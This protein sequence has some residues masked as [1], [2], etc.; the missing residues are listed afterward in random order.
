MGRQVSVERAVVP[1]ESAGLMGLLGPFISKC[2]VKRYFE[3]K[4]V[5]YCSTDFP[6]I[7][8]FT[9]VHN[10]LTGIFHSVDSNLLLFILI[11]I[12][13][14]FGVSRSPFQD[15]TCI[16]LTSFHHILNTVCG[17][18]GTLSAFPV[19]ALDSATSPEPG[20]QGG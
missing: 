12:L 15:G 7:H 8:A 4:K 3:M 2:L 6:C 1:R 13:F 18:Q 9:Y 16:F 19:P 10:D 20:I 17:A 14:L 11:L 5:F